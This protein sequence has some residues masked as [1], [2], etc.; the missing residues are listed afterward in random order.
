MAC[1]IR[2]RLIREKLEDS[3]RKAESGNNKTYAEIAKKAIEQIRIPETTTQI[4]LSELNH[5]KILISIMHTHIM[6]QT[7]LANIKKN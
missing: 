6:N 5:T 7:T 3:K 4:N 2:K 1:P